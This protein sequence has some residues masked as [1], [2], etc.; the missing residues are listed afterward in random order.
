MRLKESLL[1]TLVSLS[2]LYFITP[3]G[4][5]LSSLTAI[6]CV[7]FLINGHVISYALRLGLGVLLIVAAF[8]YFLLD[9]QDTYY[10]NKLFAVILFYFVIS[11][12][13]NNFTD[14]M[15]S[16]IKWSL[17]F[18]LFYSLF[19]S[20]SYILGYSELLL[21]AN[22]GENNLSPIGHLRC[23]TF[24]EGN[25]FGH[26]LSLSALF[27]YRNKKILNL[28][29]VG[30]IVSFSPTA[31]VTTFFINVLS[32]LRH[33]EKVTFFALIVFLVALIPF[34]RL[35]LDQLEQA[36]SSEMTSTSER[37]E[38]VSASLR[39]FINNPWFGL[40]F[41]Q[42]G[43][44]LPSYTNFIHLISNSQDGLRYIPNNVFAETFAEQ[45]FFGIAALFP[46]LLRCFKTS[47][48]LYSI[49][50]PFLVIIIDFLTMPTIYMVYVAVLIGAVLANNKD[51]G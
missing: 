22:C 11:I 10:F 16:A 46:L 32:R 36:L 6:F 5:P 13:R 37:L 15:G 17:Y 27:F 8:Q 7:P 39:M 35:I 18:V 25:Y 21:P 43:V 38:F 42:Y 48:K 23:G 47:P 3:L 29:C 20:G 24:G 51:C 14:S 41:G 19:A 31:I 26:Y 40:G 33:P 12:V 30:A 2:P 28:I 4:V 50:V 44:V 49:S 1:I 9:L 45:G 34:D